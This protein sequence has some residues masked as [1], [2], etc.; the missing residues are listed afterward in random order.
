MS[1]QQKVTSLASRKGRLTVLGAGVAV[2]ALG[3]AGCGPSLTMVS[4]HGSESQAV[5]QSTL[6]GEKNVTFDKSPVIS[7]ENGRITTVAVSGPNGKPVGGEPINGGTA[8]KID[9]TD[10]DFG[11]STPSP[12]T[13]WTCAARETNTTDSFRTFPGEGT[14]RHDQP[15]RRRHLRGRDADPDDLQP[16]DR[17]SGGHREKLGSPST[18]RRSRGRALGQRHGGHPTGPRNTGRPPASRT[19]R[20]DQGCERR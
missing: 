15:H 8:W 9:T 4:A 12:P 18:V 3:V 2:V 19:R 7:V 13:Q 6:F 1:Q 16:A 14:D 11:T 5:I 20:R 17:E 10:L